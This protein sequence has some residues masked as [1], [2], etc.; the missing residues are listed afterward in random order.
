MIEVLELQPGLLNILHFQQ[1]RIKA[2]AATLSSEYHRKNRMRMIQSPRTTFPKVWWAILF[3]VS[4][5][6]LTA[7]CLDRHSRMFTYFVD[8]KLQFKL[9]CVCVNEEAGIRWNRTENHYHPILFSEFSLKCILRKENS[10][11]IFFFVCVHLAEAVIFSYCVIPVLFFLHSLKLHVTMFS[12]H[13]NWS[14][15]T[16]WFGTISLYCSA[17]LLSIV[18]T[19]PKKHFNICKLSVLFR[20]L[21]TWAIH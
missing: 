7:H 13:R 15:G 5:F 12:V 17:F 4:F 10:P 14:N 8:V 6:S 18:R 11:T 2:A 16:L 19:R 1:Y 3:R 9:C 20:R 21:W